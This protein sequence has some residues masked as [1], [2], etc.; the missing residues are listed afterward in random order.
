MRGVGDEVL[1]H[2]LEAHLPRHVPH[3]QQRLAAA[4]GH[5]LQ[6]QIHVEL[7]RRPD[8]QRH[9]KV[10]AVQVV[11]KLRGADQVV[12]PQAHIDRPPQSEQARG[13]TVEPDNLALRAQDD[14]AVGERGGG[15]PQF[16]V[17]LHQALL[18][19]LLAAMQAY[20]L[21]NDVAPDPADSGR[22]DLRSQPQPA[23]HPVQVQ[24]LPGQ[25]RPSSSHN[26]QPNRPDQQARA[27]AQQQNSREPRER[28]GPHRSHGLE[29]GS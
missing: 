4:I 29:L 26:P 19:V 6:R 2:G 22:I 28:E 15:T 9:R 20:D 24:Q 5:H 13:L 11:S 8:H 1:A 12:D 16:T 14:D 10:I 17:E 21:G 18:V 23:V 7:H 25:V 3:Q 27:Q